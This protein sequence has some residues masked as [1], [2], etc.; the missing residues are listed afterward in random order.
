MT[1]RYLTRAGYEKLERDLDHLVKVELPE[2]ERELAIAKE[3][4]LPED[5]PP[6][7]ILS[8]KDYIENR[9]TQIKTALAEAEVL[10]EDPDPDIASPGDV[11]IVEDMETGEELRLVLLDGA[12]VIQGRGGVALD[13]P[14]GR[15]LLGKRVG[16]E[17]KVKVPDGTVIYRVVRFED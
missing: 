2:V 9:I 4:M 16:E 17:I 11:V 14:V 1:Q 12:E 3:D 13:S 7:D 5:P 15:A 10:D 8:R 6:I